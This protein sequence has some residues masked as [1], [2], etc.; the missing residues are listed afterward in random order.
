MNAHAQ[1]CEQNERD[2]HEPCE[3]QP[4]EADDERHREL[5]VAHADVAPRR[6]EPQR[7]ALL[8]ESG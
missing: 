8:A 3:P 6:V 7:E 2:P 5:H 4:A 1:S